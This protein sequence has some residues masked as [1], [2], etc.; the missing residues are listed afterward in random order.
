MFVEL[1]Y[2][3]GWERAV[4][5]VRGRRADAGSC[6]PGAWPR[7]TR[8]T[9]TQ[10]ARQLSVLVEADLPFK[11]TA[12]LHHAWPTPGPDPDRPRQ[13]GFLSLLAAV[14]AL[15]EGASQAEAAE[16]LAGSGRDRALSAT[17][18]WAT[19]GPQAFV[20]GYGASAAAG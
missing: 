16:L 8:P 9:A 17:A 7:P 15:V 11:A 1:P 18:G 12:G 20:D 13:H 6:G 14:D 19:L 5:V 4:E 2:A 10:L 3:R